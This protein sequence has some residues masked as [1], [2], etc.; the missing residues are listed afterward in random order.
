MGVDYGDAMNTSKQP[1][2]LRRPDPPPELEQDHCGNV[3]MDAPSRESAEYWI[4][5]ATVALVTLS[6]M[7]V[8]NEFCK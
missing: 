1:T 7:G 4:K 3:L 2:F 8:I 5:I 6:A